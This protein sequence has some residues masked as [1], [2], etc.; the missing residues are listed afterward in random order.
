[1]KLELA[2]I[3]K[4]HPLLIGYPVDL[5]AMGGLALQRAGHTSPTSV[6][7]E[8]EQENASGVIN[9]S[10]QDLC[11]LKMTDA[12]R[13]T[14]DGAESVALIYA[15]AKDGW[16]VKR[17]LQRGESADWLMFNKSGWL[18]LEVS[19]MISGDH[20]GRL[21]QKK[22]QI[23]RSTIPATRLAIVV[24]FKDPLILVGSI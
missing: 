11:L 15:H 23:S 2:S 9:W 18:A 20:A 13:I 16:N 3:L 12:N 10:A 8:Q 7:I 17:R 19:G 24:S 6:N 5:A 21:S 14:E 4:I 1:M 22:E